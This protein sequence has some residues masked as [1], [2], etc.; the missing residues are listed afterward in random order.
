MSQTKKQTH[1]EVIAN[2]II[3]IIIGWLIV[4]LVFPLLSSLSQGELATVSSAMFFV[5]SYVRI[6]VI[7]RIFERMRK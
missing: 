4:Y 7:R 6:Y 5:A 2:Q 1:I 3:G